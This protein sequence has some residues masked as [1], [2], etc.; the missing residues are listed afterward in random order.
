MQCPAGRVIEVVSAHI[1]SPYPCVPY[2]SWPR[3]SRACDNQPYCMVLAK[4][5]NAGELLDI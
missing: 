2:D 5:E 3:V 4:A 1:F